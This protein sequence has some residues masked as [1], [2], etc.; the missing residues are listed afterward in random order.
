MV[1][2]RYSRFSLPLFWFM[3][4]MSSRRKSFRWLHEN[5][6]IRSYSRSRSSALFSILFSVLLTWSSSFSIVK[7]IPVNSDDKRLLFIVFRILFFKLTS[8]L[9]IFSGTI[10]RVSSLLVSLSLILTSVSWAVISLLFERLNSCRISLSISHSS[11]RR[12]PGLLSSRAFAC[13]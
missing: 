2:K 12:M 13:A 7:L 9:L 6:R 3:Y 11:F 4:L 1:P 10:G 5:E 8:G